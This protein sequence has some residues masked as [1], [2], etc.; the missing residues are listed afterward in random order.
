MQGKKLI[1]VLLTLF[2]FAVLLPAQ[3]SQTGGMRGQVVDKE[4]VPLPGVSITVTGPALIGRETTVTNEKGSFRIASLPPGKEYSV[5]AELTGFQPAK[6]EMLIVQVGAT[7]TIEIQLLMSEIQTEVVV[8]ATAPV[9]D[10]AQA[11][12]AQTVTKEVLT[13]LPLSRNY[14]SASQIAPAVQERRVHGGT[15]NDTGLMVDGASANAANQGFAEVNL[16]WDTIEE[17]E[18]ITGAVSAETGNSVG[19]VMNVVTKSGGEKFSFSAW[20]YYTNENLSQSLFSPEQLAALKVAPPSFPIFNGDYGASLGGPVFK[21]KMW[22]YTN[23]NFQNRASVNTFRPTTILGKYYGQYDFPETEYY[24]FLKLTAQVTKRFRIQLMG[25][26]WNRPK[27]YN[28][29]AWNATAESNQKNN[30]H[31]ETGSAGLTYL[32]NDNNFLEGRFGLWRHESKMPYSIEGTE[33]NPRFTDGYTSYTWGSGGANRI[34]QK[35]NYNA[36]LKWTHFQDDF[37]GADHEIKMG[38][39]VQY[40][41][42][43]ADEWRQNSISNWNYYNGNPY[44]YRGLYGLNGPHPTYGDGQLQFTTLGLESLA[45]PTYERKI[46]YGGFI[47]DSF[48]IQNRLTINFGLRFEYI[49]GWMPDVVSQG[50][51][52]L[53]KAIGREYFLPAY[54]FNPYDYNTYSGW[55]PALTYQRLTP[56]LGIVYDIFKNGKTALKLAYGQYAEQLPTVTFSS[57]FPGGARA[58]NFYWWDLNNNAQPDLPSIDRYQ[59]YGASPTEMQSTVYQ[60][61]IDPKIKVPYANSYSVAIEH[62]ALPDLKISLAYIYQ[63]R[64]NVAEDVLFDLNTNQRWDTYEAAPSWWVPFQTTIPAYGT[65]P[66]KEMTMYFMS[67]NAPAQVTRLINVP[68][69][70]RIYQDVELTLNKRMSHGW[71]LGAS[72]VYASLKGNFSYGYSGNIWTAAF[73]NPSWYINREGTIADTTPWI[74]KAWGSFTLP[75]DF[76]ASFF[77]IYQ[78]G[79]PWGRTVTV[80]PP[81]AWAAANNAQSLSYAV[82]VEPSGTR[83]TSD[84][85]NVDVRIEKNFKLG[86]LGRLGFFLD[87]FNL[88]GNGNLNITTNPAG[89][90]KPTDAGTTAGTFSPGQMIVTGVNGTRIFKLS[91]R[92]TF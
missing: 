9:I 69:A 29:M 31:Q 36:S 50:A 14:I 19:G 62:E 88:L 30:A 64:K 44:Y 52:E 2:S 15:R 5:L 6:R 63:D 10:T 81:T 43:L 45:S 42:Q 77:M 27:P 85:T 71:Q 58:F 11:K 20:A 34:G 1:C 37:L 18:L 4:G 82:Q 8:I 70:K 66:A 3:V 12:M 28:S 35:R 61:R 40:G 89:T 91:A 55:D 65:F 7:V 83:W 80:A 92:F 90:W 59:Q 26:L 72:L 47:Q 75:Y 86:K 67:I 16:S 53:A 49:R 25:T 51:D 60:S 41:L 68:E 24:G 13:A 87:V 22:F 73:N 78:S 84:S 57:V 21:D 32:L 79:S 54:G 56:S 39:E 33:N 76:L 17:I 38:A 46:R 23:F 74:F 48:T